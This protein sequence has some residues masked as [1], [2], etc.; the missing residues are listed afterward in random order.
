MVMDT[1][2]VTGFLRRT[3]KIEELAMALESELADLD[4]TPTTIGDDVNASL[5][6]KI[7]HV[8]A[9]LR[10]QLKQSEERQADFK[11]ENK[12]LKTKVTNL[13][14]YISKLL[15]KKE[16]LTERVESLETELTKQDMASAAA[17]NQ[18]RGNLQKKLED[19]QAEV[20]SLKAENRALATQNE[21]LK[22][23]EGFSK[24][25]LLE[26]LGEVRSELIK[27]N[28][29]N[30]RLVAANEKTKNRLQPIM[31]GS[32]PI[33][34]MS[35]EA[36]EQFMTQLMDIRKHMVEMAAENDELKEKLA[37]GSGKKNGLQEK[38]AIMRSQLQELKGE[39]QQEQKMRQDVAQ[40]EARQKEGFIAGLQEI[41]KD[42]EG[43]KAKISE[44]T[45]KLAKAE[46]EDP[47]EQ[48]RRE[49]VVAGLQEIRSECE[50]YKNQIDE[51]RNENESFKQKIASRELV[52]M[53]EMEDFRQSV[54][55][56]IVKLSEEKA[57]LSKKVAELEKKSR[58]KNQKS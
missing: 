47:E 6:S 31:A 12:T 20:V 25:S 49:L 29:D 56:S 55:E 51:L 46:A 8:N 44:L 4:D 35:K 16:T 3:E 1:S 13:S 30:A 38:L 21:E 15:R 11:N 42:C 24:T 45:E 27:L 2:L 52:P 36:K 54:R 28:E 18:K 57:S 22:L 7:K 26:T 5:A 48:K 32:T 14:E 33:N 53:Q 9:D 19:A 58:K 50:S 10:N 23:P 43:Y 41:K 40:A 17:K 39:A 37:S 34:D